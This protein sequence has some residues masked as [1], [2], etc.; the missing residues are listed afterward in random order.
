MKKILRDHG[1]QADFVGGA[2]DSGSVASDLPQELLELAHFQDGVLTTSQ[3]IG[4]GL[5]NAILEHRVR[6]GSWQRLHTGVYAVFSGEP[7]RRAVLWAAVLRGGP[8]AM[9]SYHTAAELAELI[10]RPAPVIHLTVPADRRVDKFRGVI[11]HRSDRIDQARHPVMTPPRTRIEE[12]VLDLAGSATTL[13]DAYGWVTRAIGR[14]LT[15]QERLRDAMALRT[16]M[17]WRNA[18]APALTAD[19]DGVHSVLEYRYVRGVERPHALPRGI[20]QARVRRSGRT[21]Y[22]DVLYEEYDLAVEL[23]GQAAHPGDTR[24]LDIRRDNAAAVDGVLTLRYGWLD[25]SQHPCLVAA[26]IVQVLRRNGYVGGRGCSP[27][28]PVSAV[29]Q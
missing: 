12:T 28:C 16:R 7:G 11:V 9:L 29:G 22:R 19:A 14:R 15:T 8:G 18:L 5:T 20:R 2:D 26:Q 6:R 25:V 13:D 24:W 21:Q 3:A 23:D 1:T 10:D 4:G 27:T 17:R